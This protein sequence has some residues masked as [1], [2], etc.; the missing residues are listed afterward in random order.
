VTETHLAM[1]EHS[2]YNTNDTK[3]QNDAKEEESPM[4]TTIFVGSFA[5]KGGKG[6]YTFEGDTDTGAITPLALTEQDNPSYVA[7]SNDEKHLYCVIEV[8]QRNGQPGGAV[9]CYD[10]LPGGELR[11]VNEQSTLAGGPTHLSLSN[12]HSHLFAANYG[13]GTAVCYPIEADGSIGGNATVLPHEG[14][15]PNPQRQQKPFAHFA[16]QAP[17]EKWLCVVDLGIDGV[18]LHPYTKEKGAVLEG[19]VKV[20]ASAPGVGPRHMIF[21]TDGKTA[22]VVCELISQIDV[23]D[24]LGEQ[25][26]KLKQTI[27]TLPEGFDS[28]SACA[29]I[30]ISACGKFVYASNRGHDSVAAF[31]V[32]DDGTLTLVGITPTGGK[33]P[34]DINLM[35]GGKF[36]LCA[37][38]DE[39][40]ITVLKIE[41]DGSL[42]PTD[43]AVDTPAPVCFAFTTPQ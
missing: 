23:Y 7:I 40:G 11:F 43:I 29:A 14:S 21:S 6:I 10:I 19:S 13:G 30:R 12:D 37:N 8:G 35:P 25:G 28:F 17:D 20:P 18:M 4:K 26:M 9:A 34:R 24:Y 41:A 1:T 42:S 36:V 27:S 33:N 39:G 16:L 22:Y 3:N 2:S 38:Q 15:G 31:A 5:Y 32:Q